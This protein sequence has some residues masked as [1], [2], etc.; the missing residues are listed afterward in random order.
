L[1]LFAGL[2]LELAEGQVVDIQ[3]IVL[4][5]VYTLKLPSSLDRRFEN[6]HH[7]VRHRYLGIYPLLGD[8]YAA[9]NAEGLPSGAH[10]TC[11]GF[12]V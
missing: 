11:E 12:R 4:V 7:I 5:D 1:D 2:D 10:A 8:V 6:R 9:E 3:R